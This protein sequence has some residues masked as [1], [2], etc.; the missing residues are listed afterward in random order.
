MSDNIIETVD[1]CYTY[2]GSARRSLDGVSI[3]IR[4][5]S[6]T[7]ILGAN[8]A[9]KSTLFYQFNGVSEPEKGKVLFDGEP[10]SYKRR[11]LRALRSRV[12]VV[13]QNPDDQIFGQT[14]EADVAYGPSNMG[15]PADEVEARVASALHEVGLEDLRKRV[16]GQL[17][18]GQRK[19]LALAG[20]LAMRPE[21]LVL[22]EPTAGMDPQ[23]A[24]DVMELAN[25]L[26]A[27]GTTVVISTHDV[28]LRTR[29]RRRSTCSYTGGSSSRDA[30]RSSTPTPPASALRASP[31]PW[32]SQ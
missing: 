8:G 28:D 7:V 30:P 5:G 18:Y 22:D 10:V 17:S 11:H 3:G 32:C 2:D 23:M 21:I 24:H 19:R 14:V 27:D 1:L 15:L 12:A 16:T 9:G 4:R 31:C 25:Q 26:H 6:K 29:G 20:A 13:L